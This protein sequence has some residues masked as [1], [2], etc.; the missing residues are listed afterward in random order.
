MK[1]GKVGFEPLFRNPGFTSK[2]IS[3]IFD[4]A[5][6]ITEWGSFRSEFRE[7]GRLRHILQGVPMYFT[8]ATMPDHVLAD[9]LKT[10]HIP[11]S[12][13]HVFHRS[14][15]RPNVFIAVREIK[16]SFSSFKDLD[17][18]IEGWAIGRSRPRKFLVLFDSIR[19]SVEAALHLRA[20][21]PLRLRNMVKWHNSHMST[22]YKERAIE[23]FLKGNIIGFCATDTLGMVSTIFITFFQCLITLH[24]EWISRTSSL[25]YSIVYTSLPCALYYS[26]WVGGLAIPISRLYLFFLPSLS[27]SSGISRLRPRRPERN[28]HLQ[29]PV[30][31]PPT[32]G[33]GRLP[34]KKPPPSRPDDNPTINQADVEVLHTVMSFQDFLQ[35]RLHAYNQY[36][37]ALSKDTK[38]LEPK[39]PEDL[40]PS[41]CDIIN[42]G[43][44]GL[45][46]ERIPITLVFKNNKLRTLSYYLLGVSPT[47]VT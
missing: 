44:I 19:E 16:H 40:D 42:A 26:A 36:F 41:L 45:G 9:L 43:D 1:P 11:R 3:L 31:S 22:E 4:E 25:S 5:H 8:S 27:F 35:S 18:L 38:Q 21:L 47:N 30:P 34:S 46:C 20:Q 23:E 17:F 2:I 29:I 37:R 33:R 13:L 15:D 24:R 14:N 7:V 10:I 12:N 32:N 39:G 6:C 28:E